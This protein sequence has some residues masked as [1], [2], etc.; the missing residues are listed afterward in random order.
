MQTRLQLSAVF[1]EDP[2]I[3]W[4]EAQAQ[5]QTQARRSDAGRATKKKRKRKK[6]SINKSGTVVPRHACST[7]TVAKC[8][9]GPEDIIVCEC[10]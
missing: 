9:Y 3:G 7:N 6:N 5:A 2:T 10:E 1:P 8:R 4:A